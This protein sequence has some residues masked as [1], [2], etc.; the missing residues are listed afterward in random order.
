MLTLISALD[1]K[2]RTT[3][4]SIIC[5][6]QEESAA[7]ELYMNGHTLGLHPQT[8]EIEPPPTA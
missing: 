1:I 4:Y 7:Q 5:R 3:L 8:Q 2:A 6:T